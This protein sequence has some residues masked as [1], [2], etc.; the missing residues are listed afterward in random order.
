MPIC[1]FSTPLSE[2]IGAIHVAKCFQMQVLQLLPL[3]K[4]FFT[5]FHAAEIHVDIET[6]PSLLLITLL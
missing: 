5:V 4:S 1:I 6:Q 2:N 3:L